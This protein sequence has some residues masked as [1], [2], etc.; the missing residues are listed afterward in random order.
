VI[1][2][3]N[4]NGGSSAHVVRQMT[5]VPSPNQQRLNGRQRLNGPRQSPAR[6]QRLLSA[7]PLAVARTI[8]N[9]AGWPRWSPELH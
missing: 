7:M 9:N 8:E 2:V 4:V 5:R 3:L 1:N 6:M